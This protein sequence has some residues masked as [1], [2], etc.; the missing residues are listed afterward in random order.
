MRNLENLAVKENR[1]RLANSLPFESVCDG[2]YSRDT[3]LFHVIHL[4]FLF[5]LSFQ[6]CT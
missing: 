2:F 6:R 5:R 3:F 4:V 1:I